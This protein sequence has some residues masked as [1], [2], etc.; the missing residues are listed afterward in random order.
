[1]H[2]LNN[3]VV[4]VRRE[5]D[6]NVVLEKVARLVEGR[7]TAVHVV[8]VVHDPVIDAS[9]ASVADR[10]RMKTFMM[11][12]EEQYLEELLD[13]FR[14]RIQNL[15]S[16]TM[17]H[18]RPFRAVLDLAEDVK[19]DLIV[20]AAEVKA[21]LSEVVRTPDDWHLVRTSQVPVLLLKPTMWVRSAQVIAAV[22]TF[23][24]DADAH[25]RQVITT[26]ELMRGALGGT[27]HVVTAFPAYQPWATELGAAFDHD[28]LKREIEHEIDTQQRRLLDQ[29]G[30]HAT[31][32]AVEGT[33]AFAVSD[34]AE[35]I[36]AELIVLATHA[37]K[38]VKA[39]VLGNTSESLLHLSQRD[40]LVLPA[41]DA[42]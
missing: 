30:I 16:V 6:T 8:R 18:A 29:C 14:A 23:D 39:L 33:P 1:M 15:D 2:A 35:S 25:N 36:G 5:P 9:H 12:T 34:Y 10:Q 40:L 28:R 22:D 11:Q 26:A 27:L 31:R 37:R 13:P 3:I 41:G 20:R 4:N 38:G 19:P 32:R 17:W 7:R 21:R 24:H 42:G